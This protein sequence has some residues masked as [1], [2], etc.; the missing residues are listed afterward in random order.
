MN[1]YNSIT[2]HPLSASTQEKRYL[3]SCEGR[4]YETSSSIAE[5][6]VELQQNVTQEEAVNAYIHKTGGR[7]TAE[8]I[9]QVINKFIVPVLS[10]PKQQKRTFL[11]EKELF[12]ATAIDRFSDAFR[13]LFNKIYM[14][15]VGIVVL[16]LDVLFFTQTSD[17]LIF[18]DKVNAYTIIGILLFMLAS[19][20]FHELGHASACKYF[21]IRHGGIGFGLYLNF[22]VLYTDVTEVWKLQRKQ[23]LI[24]NV[25]GIYFQS[26]CLTGLLIGFMLTGNNMLRY[27]ILIMNLGFLMTL[28]PF[29][30]FDGYWLVSDLLGVPNLRNRSKELLAYLYKR[31]RK[32]P[33][34]KK[35]YLFQIRKVRLQ[36]VVNELWQSSFS[37]LYQF[38]VDEV[39]RECF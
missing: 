31:L 21:G 5:L 14:I 30:K 8:Q 18:N 15:C 11:Y 23:R 36:F 29:F 9:K 33:V 24:V 17:L 12:P 34:N 35:P 22:P 27:L 3:L 37:L 20:F 38:R 32:Y 26:F 19:S 6:L 10:V 28:N 39:K 7:Y 2:I 25:A 16:V 13:F 4:Y 1:E